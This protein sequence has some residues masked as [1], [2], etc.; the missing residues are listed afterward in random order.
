MRNRLMS[1]RYNVLVLGKTVFL[2]VLPMTEALWLNLHKGESVILGTFLSLLDQLG[3]VLQT[4]Q[5][6][7]EFTKNPVESKCDQI[8]SK[9]GYHSDCQLCPT[10]LGNI[11][12]KSC[13]FALLEHSYNLCQTQSSSLFTFNVSKLCITC[14]VC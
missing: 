8:S 5:T 11:V 4:L 2:P 7:Y 6:R 3:I 14:P 1:M 12:L 10:N 13:C 9:L